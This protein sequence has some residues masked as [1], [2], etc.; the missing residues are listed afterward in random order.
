[1]QKGPLTA[2]FWLEPVRL[3]NSYG[4]DARTFRRLSDIVEANSDRIRLAW[5][6]HLANNLWFDKDTMWVDLCFGRTLG[7]PLAWI[8]RLLSAR[9]AD[10]LKFGISGGGAGLHWPELDED[11]SVEGLLAGR[12]YMTKPKARAAAE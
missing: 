5:H 1:V 6:D 3:A 4:F 8:P 2:K 12:G 11:I 7:I 10:L 9:H